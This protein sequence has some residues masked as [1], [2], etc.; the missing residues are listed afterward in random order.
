MNPQISDTTNAD[1]NGLDEACGGTDLP[2]E[3]T[4]AGLVN[5]IPIEESLFEDEDIDELELE[6]LEIVD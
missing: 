4:V 2:D 5:G 1:E 6:D 3:D